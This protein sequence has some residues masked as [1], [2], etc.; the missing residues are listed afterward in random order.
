MEAVIIIAVVVV[1]AAF[2][3][4]LS[5]FGSSTILLPVLL[6]LD[7]PLA[8]ALLL[9][10]I[11]HWFNDIWKLTLFKKGIKWKLILGF[12]IPGVLLTYIGARLAFN[13]PEELL[14]QILGA[15]LIGYALFL[16]VHHTFKVKPHM[17]AAV[18]GGSLSGFFAGIF[19]LGGA[20]R[21]AF[22]A[23]YNLPKSVYI[24]TAGAIAFAID[25]VRIGTYVTEGAQL[26][27]LFWWGLILFIP[28]SYLGAVIAK[29]TV[30]KIPQKY[31][32]AVV[33]LFLLAAGMK[34]LIFA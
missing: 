11:L 22:L 10:G 1:I 23:A 26:R 18:V 31:F 24:A 25:T 19:G 9:A 16:I 28:L 33:A 27:E 32:R 2:V 14:S 4:T 3:G 21:G 29:K 15:F 17:G 13:A 5:G 12:G 34:F 30:N 7:V 6:L 8:E 20:I